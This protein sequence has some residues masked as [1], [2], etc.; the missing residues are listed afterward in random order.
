MKDENKNEDANLQSP[1][2]NP[3]TIDPEFISDLPPEVREMVK[4]QLSSFTG[5]LPN[6]LI[7]K[8][9]PDHIT[10][11]I[12]NEKQEDNNRY[13]YAWS[14]R[15]FKAFYVVL[16]V[17]FLV[18][19]ITYLKSNDSELLIKILEILVAFASGVGV[20]IGYMSIKK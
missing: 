1:K 16:V 10:N 20:G 5:K 2:D 14:D 9:T 19:L 13:K 15:Y 18:F 12:D 8:L 7:N 17:G 6:P 4:F 11:I 3:E